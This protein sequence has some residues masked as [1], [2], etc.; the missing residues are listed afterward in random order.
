[1]EDFKPQDYITADRSSP[2]SILIQVTRQATIK[3][4]HSSIIG[5]QD[6]HYK[7]VRRPPM[8][9]NMGLT[10]VFSGLLWETIDV[11]SE[12]IRQLPDTFAVASIFAKIVPKSNV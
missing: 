5:I 10:T 11:S 4:Y 1:M 7:A 2:S 6:K 9:L 12:H 8:F 3:T